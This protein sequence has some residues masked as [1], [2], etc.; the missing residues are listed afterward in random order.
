MRVP[1]G[2]LAEP[3]GVVRGAE[4]VVGS[5]LPQDRVFIVT[6]RTAIQHRL[7]RAWERFDTASDLVVPAG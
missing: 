6:D 7:G 5:S 2:G 3:L 4:T 1:I